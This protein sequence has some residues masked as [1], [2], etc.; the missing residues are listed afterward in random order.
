MAL[1]QFSDRTLLRLADATERSAILSNDVGRRILDCTYRF[2]QPLQRVTAIRVRGV[3][4]AA[5]VPDEVTFHGRVWQLDTAMQAEADGSL[6]GYIRRSII[7]AHLDVVVTAST[8]PVNATVEAVEVDHI[9][10]I[11]DLQAVDARIVAEDGAIPAGSDD[12]DARRLDVMKARFRERFQATEDF[13]VNE[14]GVGSGVDVDAFLSEY[15]VA[16][17]AGFV[18]LLQERGHSLRVAM[19][20][21][22]EPEAAFRNVEFEVP[23]SVKVAEDPVARLRETVEEIQVAR[24][25]LGRAGERR[26]SSTTPQTQNDLPF[27]LVFSIESLDDGDLPLPAGSPQGGTREQLRE[28]RLAELGRRLQP[29][30]VALAPV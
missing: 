4:V 11:V 13:V 7:D 23:L 21:V 18:D 14:L 6:N 30:G 29:V 25:M 20:I 3:E 22:I 12:L 2:T 16:T 1:V 27:L 5:P 26:V 9:D 24:G 19:D 17:A 15:G 28:R 10:D 8:R